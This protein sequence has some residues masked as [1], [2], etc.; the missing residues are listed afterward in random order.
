M[1][2]FKLIPEITYD[3]IKVRNLFHRYY[4]TQ[5]IDDKY[6][7]SYTINDGDTLES[8]S[9]EFYGST[10]YWWIIAVINNINDV[11]YDMPI[12]H[13][14]LQ[15]IAKEQATVDGTLDL[16]LFSSI[17]DELEQENNLKRTIKIIK[18]DYLNFVLSDI[19]K[20][21]NESK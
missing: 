11:I 5:D 6:L 15:D 16:E 10:D 4:L 2:F 1:E 20:K 21:F 17:F 18:Q 7:S 3:N 9:Y 12:P 8:I 14:V 19:I 13:F